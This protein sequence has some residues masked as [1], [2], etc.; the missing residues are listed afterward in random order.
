MSAREDSGTGTIADDD[1][2]MIR[3]E[4]EIRLGHIERR[5]VERVRIKKVTVTENERR[6]IPVRREVIQLEHEPPPSGQIESVEDVPED[7]S[8]RTSEK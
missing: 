8:Q 3:S 2:A 5:P 1:D 7:E 4:E 6:M